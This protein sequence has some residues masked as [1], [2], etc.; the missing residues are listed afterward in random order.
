MQDY[1]HA[2][3]GLS[4]VS[5]RRMRARRAPCPLL[6]DQAY[7]LAYIDGFMVLGFAVIGALL[8]M[9]LLRSRRRSPGRCNTQGVLRRKVHLSCLPC[10]T[11][12]RSKYSGVPIR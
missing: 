8:L 12:N 4:V 9:L 10:S 7:V 1:A 2:V 6:Q 3:T 11:Q 5:P